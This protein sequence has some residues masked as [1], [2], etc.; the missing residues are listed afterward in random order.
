[1]ATAKK[2]AAKS[3]PAKKAPVKRAPA[4][5]AV[6]AKK[7]VKP[8][9]AVKAPAEPNPVGRPT[10]FKPEYVELAY[11]FALLGATDKRMAELFQV[12]EQTF[13]A[14]KHAHPQ[15]LE[16]LTRGRDI[17]DAEIAHSLY[18]RAKGYEHPEDDI[19]SV[20]LGGNAGSEIVITPTIKRYPPDTG[21][22]ALWLANRQRGRWH[23]KVEHEHSGPGGG[24]IQTENKTTHTADE[25][26]KR[27]LGL[28]T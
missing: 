17:A 5:K 24:P 16:S 23:Q 26:Y 15:F 20:A 4:K 9:S 7:K 2:P 18:H 10:S 19:K 21:A 11:K 12:S 22:A 1:M 25:A 14:W 3:T 28:P 6:P 8:V 27:M 13:N